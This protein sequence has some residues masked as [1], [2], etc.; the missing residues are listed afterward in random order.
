MTKNIV[1]VHGFGVRKDDRGL[2]TDIAKVLPDYACHFFDMNDVDEK[3]GN[4][5]TPPLEEQARRLS[6]H[7]R[8]HYTKP[9]V[10]IA[11]SM[12]CIVS[13]LLHDIS[14]QKMIFLTPPLKVDLEK[15]VRSF[16]ERPGSVIDLQGTS[17]LTRRDGTTTTVPAEFW[18]SKV[19]HDPI[20]TY[21]TIPTTIPVDF[22]MA[23]QDEVL[24]ISGAPDL[25]PHFRIVTLTGDH[26]FSAPADRPPVLDYVKSQIK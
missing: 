1:F 25:P 4:L 16:Q 15:F 9:D 21:K 22:V 2:F 14:P 10:I 13:C 12:G 7:L 17:L 3:T 26:N 18:T 11:H 24:G 6:E 5:F 19:R 23:D 8:A 20:P